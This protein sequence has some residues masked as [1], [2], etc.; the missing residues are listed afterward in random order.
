VFV[1]PVEVED[2]LLQ[3]PAVGLAAVV[4]VEREG[5]VKPVAYV[6]VREEERGRAASEEGRARLAAE[7]ED[8]CVARLSRHKVP[9]SFAFVDDLPKND[10][11]KVDRR[12]LQRLEAGA[13][14]GAR[15]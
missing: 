6:V 8:H 10:R 13:A 1:A 2:C 9:R 12:A 7:L 15:G 11:G 14:E 4:P 3:H 5:L